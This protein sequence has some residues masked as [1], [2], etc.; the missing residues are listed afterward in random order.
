MNFFITL[1]P[2]L[3]S[4]EAI[5]FLFP[6]LVRLNLEG[7]SLLLEEQILSYKSRPNFKELPH[8][9]KHIGILASKYSIILDDRQGAFIRAGTFIRINTV[10]AFLAHL[11]EST[12]SCCCHSD[13]SVGVTL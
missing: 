1:G 9:D 10:C 3:L 6:F 12:E 5:L 7:K 2:G 11:Y 4:K 13:V 8:S